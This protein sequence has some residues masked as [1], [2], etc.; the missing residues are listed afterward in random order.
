MAGAFLFCL[1]LL[2]HYWGQLDGSEIRT[3]VASLILAIVTALRL[4][5]L[6]L[7]IAPWRGRSPAKLRRELAMVLVLNI[8]VV[9]G[10]GYLF[11]S[12]KGAAIAFL[13]IG[14]V[15]AVVWRRASRDF[16]AIAQ[17]LAKQGEMCVVCGQLIAEFE[18]A[19]E[20]RGRWFCSPAHVLEAE[21]MA[22]R[23]RRRFWRLTAVVAAA[24]AGVAGI[25]Q[26]GR[27][28]TERQISIPAGAS[29]E[30]AKLLEGPRGSVVLFHG[31]LMPAA[32][33]VAEKYLVDEYVKRDCSAAN[34][35][36][37]A[38]ALG[39]FGE[40]PC[41]DNQFLVS[42]QGRSY[43]VR[44]T[45]RVHRHCVAYTL[46]VSECYIFTLID[47]TNKLRSERVAGHT[48]KRWEYL[49]TDEEVWLN[50]RHGSW[51]VVFEG[52]ESTNQNDGTPTVRKL[53]S[54]RIQSA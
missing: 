29:K 7:R 4:T 52:P 51:V 16:T 41:A 50:M 42:R 10:C 32:E 43:L 14:G 15:D 13:F 35:N 20:A 12:F 45:P 8:G 23:R 28:Q 17:R 22:A 24:V 27:S 5:Y 9:T 3:L 2:L 49:V 31:T 48:R 36:Y 11:W 54:H 19:E 37:D 34:A 39:P 26:I 21:A 30:L 53:W 40:P 44:G 46:A 18:E 1:W 47:H 38:S 33:T 25:S 6:A